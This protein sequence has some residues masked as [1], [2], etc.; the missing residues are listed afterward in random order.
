MT[1]ALWLIYIL[2]VTRWLS[3]KPFQEKETP[4]HLSGADGVCGK[5]K[6]EMSLVHSLFQD[7]QRD[8]A[9]SISDVVWELHLSG[10][11]MT[12]QLE[13]GSL[14]RE[15]TDKERR[16]GFLFFSFLRT[17]KERI[18]SVSPSYVV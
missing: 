6:Q 17:D 5:Q 18:M 12:L 10:W 2:Y 9:H 15:G 1:F 3:M 4:M 16:S 7:A 13:R 8:W 14:S 11:C